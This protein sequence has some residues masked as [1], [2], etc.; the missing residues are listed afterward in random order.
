M[1]MG[2]L[3]CLAVPAECA[4]CEVDVNAKAV[5][6]GLPDTGN[7]FALCDRIGGNKSCSYCRTYHKLCSL[8]IP[9]GNIID[10]FPYIGF[11]RL[12]ISFLR[13]RLIGIPH[14]RRVA[15]DIIQFRF[16]HDALPVDAQGVALDNV[17]IGL[18]RQEV[19]IHVDDVLRLLHHLAL[20][21]P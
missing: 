10:I 6:Q 19:Q 2:F 13:Y 14:K 7:L 20:R 9:P 16:G 3:I 21:D 18:Q 12:Q 4:V 8:E 11:Y 15:H 5:K 17:D 1:H